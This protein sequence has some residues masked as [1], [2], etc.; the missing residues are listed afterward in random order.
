MKPLLPIGILMIVVG[1]A[2][3][4][5]QQIIV[6]IA[7]GLP[8]SG[9]VWIQTLGFIVAGTGAV[10]IGTWLG[11]RRRAGQQPSARSATERRRDAQL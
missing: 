7:T 8:S 4:F 9:T 6:A 10:C 5:G 3:A 11:R 1:I 2:V